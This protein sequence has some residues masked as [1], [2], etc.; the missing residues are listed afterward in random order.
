M[1]G[2]GT[3][4]IDQG[5]RFECWNIEP[6][7]PIPSL[8]ADLAHGFEQSPRMLPPKYF[9]DS[10][11]SKL[12]EQICDTPEYY[13]TRAESAL[14]KTHATELISTIKPRHLIELGSGNSRK[15]RYLLL[16]AN[17]LRLPLDYWPFDVCRDMLEHSGHALISEFP[18]LRVRA[19]VGDYLGGLTN[20]PQPDG[21]RMFVFLGGTIGNF[22]ESESD[23]FLND[24]RTQMR[25]DDTLLLGADRL[26]NPAILEAAYND[27]AGITAAFNLNV[28]KVV[29][30][31]LQ[32]DFDLAAFRHRAIFN[33]AASRIEIYLVSRRQQQV[34]VQALKR[35]YSFDKN[36]VILTEI[37]RKYSRQSLS[38]ILERAGF[39]VERHIEGGERLFS[40][41][42]ARPTP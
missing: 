23:C 34:N 9:Y 21:P 10:T 15:T 1:N 27:A 24:L 33:D 40:L 31:E 29:N 30:R 11:G 37:S 2:I 7:W 13:P 26:K 3:S 6:A 8:A 41:V 12:F 16:A 17:D 4:T 36:E 38:A 35:T 22:S 39:T 28:L 14:L 18:Q 19:L 20:L 25:P 42:L 32:A 5:K